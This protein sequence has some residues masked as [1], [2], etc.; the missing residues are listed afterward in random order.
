M[1]QSLMNEQNVQALNK[2]TS[3]TCFTWSFLPEMSI[4]FWQTRQATIGTPSKKDLKIL[5]V[6]PIY[7]EIPCVG[8]LICIQ[9]E[10]RSCRGSKWSNGGPWTL[11]SEAWRLYMETWRVCRLAIAD[12]HRFNAFEDPIKVKKG[13]LMR[14]RNLAYRNVF[15][16]GALRE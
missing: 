12:K 5:K 4:I 2:K 15:I 8:I 11:T 13:D 9:V 1:K 16:V 3:H 10:V 6:N 7:L 14:I